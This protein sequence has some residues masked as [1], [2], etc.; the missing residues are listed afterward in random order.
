[1]N[2]SHFQLIENPSAMNN[3][4]QFTMLPKMMH[5]ILWRCWLSWN[6]NTTM[7]WTTKGGPHCLW[8]L[9][10]VQYYMYIITCHKAIIG[11]I[12]FTIYYVPVT[13]VLQET[14]TRKYTSWLHFCFSSPE[15]KAQ[16]SFSDQNL[17]VVRRRYCHRHW[18]P[19]CCCRKLFIISSS[20]PEPPGQ[21][22]PNMAQSILGWGGLKFV[23]MKGPALFQRDIITN[24]HKCIDKN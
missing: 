14:F 10:L 20:S 18:C 19:S 22:Q 24:L 23:Q 15:L 13:S 17:F 1:M 5:A 16:V 8:P 9:S 12:S 11:Y 4:P 7:S 21:Y 3:R 2:L 6:V